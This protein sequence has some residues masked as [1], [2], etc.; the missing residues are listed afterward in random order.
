MRTITR[1]FILAALAVTPAVA[2]QSV[3]RPLAPGDTVVCQ[4]RSDTTSARG[5][6]ACIVA[7]PQIVK[8]GVPE[9]PRQLQDA[10]VEGEVVVQIIVDTMG[11]PE[12]ASITIVK[13]AHPDFEPAVR[14]WVTTVEFR[15]AR[16]SGRAVRVLV[17]LPLRFALRTDAGAEASGERSEDVLA[18]GR[19]Q[20]AARHLD[21]AAALFHRVADAPARR[22]TNRVEAWVLLGVTD[23]YRSGDSAAAD[24]FRHALALDPG[25][26]V[27]ALDKFDPAIAQILATER[28]AHPPRAQAPAS[29]AAPL[30]ECLPKCAEGV[31][32][33][34]F[35][36]FPQ[37]MLT[38]EPSAGGPTGRMHTYLAL[39]AVIGADGI[40]EAETVLML[41]GTAPSTEGE[42]RQGLVR[43]RFAPGR[44]DG[45]PVRTRVTLRFDFE[46]E[47]TNGLSYT[48]RVDAR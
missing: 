2:Q 12:P 25:L 17:N 48:Y 20:L 46:A 26:E 32:P 39:Q 35:I 27:A 34:R 24:A 16:L 11:R 37:I 28:A 15:P 40:V 33:P 36:S 22:G 10:G 21:S 1:L 42:V 41:G 45:A 29:E 18:A 4:I 5:A 19:A 44:A 9:Y 3:Q 8:Q 14:A 13:T 38:A 43:A 31:R 47:G 7:P 30:Y 6:A 23:Y